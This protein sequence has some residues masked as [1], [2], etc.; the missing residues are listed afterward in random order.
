MLEE[1]EN[2]ATTD[3][4]TDYNE[5]TTD[6]ETYDISSEEFA[7]DEEEVAVG[8]DEEVYVEDEGDV[9]YEDVPA[10]TT[11]YEEPEEDDTTAG[12]AMVGGYSAPEEE[13]R[14]MADV[15]GDTVDKAGQKVEQAGEAVENA[16]KAVENT[17]QAVENVGEATENA[18]RGMQVAGNAINLAGQGLNNAATALDATEIGAVVGVPLNV[19]ATGAQ[20]AGQAV[21]SAGVS[22]EKAGT[23]VKETGKN[24]KK[25]GNDI[26]KQGQDIKKKGQ[27]IRKQGQ[28]IK[29]K[30]KRQYHHKKSN[31]AIPTS[32]TGKV[33]AKTDDKIK[34][35]LKNPKV[36]KILIPVLLVVGLLFGLLLIFLILFSDE[37]GSMG[38]S[39]K[40]S[41]GKTCT[42]ITITDSGCNGA[43]TECTNKY[44]GT[45]DLED[46]IAGV[47]AA[48]IG[49][50]NN[51]EYYKTTA[52]VARSFVLNHISDDC[53]A[54]GNATF[55]AYM[56]VEES[57]N[58][59]LIKQAVE[60]TKGQVVIKN[61]ELIGGHYASACVVNADD[62]Y[63]YVR[64]GTIS[65]GEAKFQQIPKDWDQNGS[66]FKGYLASWY[67]QV[68]Q[69]ST[70]YENKSCPSN[71]DY[72]MTQLGALYLVT[73]EGYDHEDVIEYYYGSDAEI[74]ENDM[75]LG[76]VEGFVNPT[77]VIHCSS[78]YGNRIHPVHGTQKF[79]SGLDIGIAGGEPIYA[80]KDGTVSIAVTN[81][82]SINNCN[83]GYGNYIKIDHGDGTS[84]LYAHIKYGT[85][86][87][88]ITVGS[89]VSQGEQIGQVG[90]TGCSTG[91]HLHYEV[92]VNGQTV[93]PADYIDLT[94]ATGS[95][96]R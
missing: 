84:T 17:G 31:G 88:S 65:L 32:G 95:C 62:N 52:I 51:L 10:D 2:L 54:K 35:T 72:G 7:D 63:Y 44:D 29:N 49:T 74:V 21:N 90:S 26:K 9:V 67:S 13:K 77:R 78:A 61:G 8:E 4:S 5:E 94:G 93:D 89:E 56:D 28:E 87:S 80:A 71:H 16:G 96:K 58:A 39:G 53:T 30:G 34:A 60:E 1:D 86:P 23:S 43:A 19:V 22:T 69:S 48:E 47:V 70:D 91:N 82:N 36:L 42:E 33:K 14:T 66:A 27:D 11:A 64:Y 24:I 75:V 20:T 25:T 59:E 15:A 45:V 79:H 12:V 41:Y 92:R 81:V 18:G 76:G 37:D 68:D 46:Y 73:E 40:F 50:A 3:D 85:I 55:Q 57:S 38:G 6:T 83:Y